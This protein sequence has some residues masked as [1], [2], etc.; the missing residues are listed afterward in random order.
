MQN[1]KDRR[2]V[3]VKEMIRDIIYQRHYNK[4]LCSS[5]GLSDQNIKLPKLEE[6]CI[7]DMTYLMEEYYFPKDDIIYNKGDQIDGIIFVIEGE[8][9]IEIKESQTYGFLLDRI[10]KR[11]TYGFHTVLKVLNA[12]D[13]ES[14]PKSEYK[15]ISKADTIVLKLP[16]KVLKNMRKKS[17]YLS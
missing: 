2:T 13:Q 11:C 7:T 3:F 5:K 17:K 9:N 8:I 6:E 16:I 10:Y 4:D 1:Y 15:L 12:S 14:L